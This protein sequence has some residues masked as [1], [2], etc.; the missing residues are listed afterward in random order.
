MI[1]F[2]ANGS[3]TLSADDRLGIALFLAAGLHAAVILGVSFQAVTPET[4][5]AEQ[6]LEIT[7]VRHLREPEEPEDAD[8]LAQASQQGGGSEE[9][10]VKPTAEPS[11][12][13]VRPREEAA[14]ETQS[15]GTPE[16]PP[17]ER[18]V[19]TV[20]DSPRPA[21]SETPKPPEPTE[22]K[23]TAAELLAQRSQ[24]IARITAELDRKTRAYA[25]R[26]RRKY[27]S[28]STQE[29]RYAFY[30][31]A[32]RKKV[33]RI[34]NLNYPEE[35]KRGRL[36][37]TLVVHCAVRS[38]GSVERVRILTSSGIK[39]LDDAAIRA[40]R[41]AAPFAP[42]PEDIAKETDILDITRT[43]RYTSDDQLVS[44]Q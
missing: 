19:I 43:F 28:A 4:P 27:V 36:Y 2:L 31:E 38:D 13:P 35:A 14:R 1:P 34:G 16:P 39:V 3:R 15:S 5:S 33:E 8:F 26:P 21:A 9:E 18:K 42:F 7:V 6:S 10:K 23:P 44:G 11:P 40:V 32:W 41:L 37:G 24:E 30:L 29:Y 17:A 22:T 20:D 12:P 25:K